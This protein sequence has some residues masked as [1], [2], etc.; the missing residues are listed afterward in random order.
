MANSGWP[1][2]MTCPGL[3]L[4]LASDAV[5][6]R[7]HRRVLK[8]QLGLGQRRLE[9]LD[10]RFGRGDARPGDGDLLGHRLRAAQ[11]RL[12]LLLA[13][14]AAPRGGF[15]PPA[16]RLRL[17]RPGRARCRLPPVGPRP[18]PPSNRTA[19]ARLRLSPAVLSAVR[20]RGSPCSHWPAL[21]ARGPAPSS[22]SP[23][24]RRSVFRSPRRRCAP[25]R[26]SSAR[27]TT[28]LDA[29]VEVSGTLLL[30]AS[31]VASASASSARALSS[32]I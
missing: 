22:A 26:P 12:R 15:P 17:R 27:S 25:D 31:R 1:A 7:L 21:R 6:R 18:P 13:G 14:A 10:A 16:R 19:A 30:A 9:L 20:H 8:V 28:P 24:P 23:W 32:A 11:R 4:F 2:W 3:T 5:D 29:V